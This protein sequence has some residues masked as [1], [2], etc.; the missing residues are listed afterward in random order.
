M[1]DRTISDISQSNIL[2]FPT[3]ETHPPLNETPVAETGAPEPAN[4]PVPADEPHYLGHRERLRNRFEQNGADS[5]SDVELLELLL[6]NLIPRRDVKELAKK[7]LSKF[8]SF[9]EVLA[10]PKSALMK[11]DGI[12]ETVAG[13]LKAIEAAAARYAR[14]SVSSKNLF[15]TIESV[16]E[17][18]RA[19]I[20]FKD[21][22]HLQILFL[23]KRNHLLR[24]EIQQSGTIDHLPAYPREIVKR[25]LECSATAIILAHNHPSGDTTPSPPDITTTKELIKVASALGINVHD[26]IIVGPYGFSSMRAL[27]L[28]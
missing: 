11:Q 2:S 22:E 8:G 17:Y 26:H 9:P 16:A 21:R 4:R 14:G 20:G 28:I 10:A 23:D 1:K 7:L 6:F 24:D 5:F 3:G 19:K 15:L 13:G 18:A 12:G 27:K 25:A